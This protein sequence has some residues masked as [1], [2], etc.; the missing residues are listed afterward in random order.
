MVAKGKPRPPQVWPAA[1]GLGPVLRTS[2]L[3]PEDE[4]RAHPCAKGTRLGVGWGGEPCSHHQGPRG[5]TLA[6]LEAGGFFRFLCGWTRPRRAGG[7]GRDGWLSGCPHRPVGLLPPPLPPAPSPVA[8]SPLS[9]PDPGPGTPILTAIIR[10][11]DYLVSQ[12]C[13]QGC[14][15]KHISTVRVT[16]RVKQKKEN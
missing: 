15:L 5:H 4:G 9:P 10:T 12:R 8:P 2:F 13:P 1:G 7:T 11:H 16:V 3:P 14:P 6:F